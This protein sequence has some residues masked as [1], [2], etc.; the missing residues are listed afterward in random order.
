MNNKEIQ[1]QFGYVTPER[2]ISSIATETGWE[3]CMAW[4]SRIVSDVSLHRSSEQQ[5]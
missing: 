4:G 5:P 3:G 2:A 1:N